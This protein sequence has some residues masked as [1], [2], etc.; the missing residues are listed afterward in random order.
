MKKKV[1]VEFET[2]TKLEC[3]NVN[4]RH[5]LVLKGKLGCNLKNIS[6]NSE[7]VCI[8]KELYH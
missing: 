2:A 8:N 1:I 4:C 5:N 7:G 3:R 6:L